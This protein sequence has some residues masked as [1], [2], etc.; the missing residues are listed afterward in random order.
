[1]VNDPFNLEPISP[2]TSP[3]ST[4]D[5]PSPMTIPLDCFEKVSEKNDE[6]EK[7]RERLIQENAKLKEENIQYRVKL[8]LKTEESYA[9]HVK[10]SQLENERKRLRKKSMLSTKKFS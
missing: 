6:L 5:P 10:K 7:E 9:V 4:M 8:R 3:V 2:P 1:M